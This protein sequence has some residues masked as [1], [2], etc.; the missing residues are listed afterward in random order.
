M[1]KCLLVEDDPALRQIGATLLD[2]AGIE[3]QAVGSG[4]EALSCLADTRFDVAVIDTR[5]PG[6]SGRALAEAIRSRPE[7]DAI[8]LFAWTAD[9]EVISSSGLPFVQVIPKPCDPPELINAVLDAGRCQVEARCTAQE[10]RPSQEKNGWR[11]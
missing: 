1:T 11:P 5:L 2:T 6:M 4:E 3:V 8:V 7:H 9:M 10:A